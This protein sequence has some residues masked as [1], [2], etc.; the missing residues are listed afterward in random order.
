MIVSLLLRLHRWIALALTLPFA[1]IVISGGLL[2]LEPILGQGEAAPRSPAD[3][4]AL[5]A[6]AERPEAAT[7]RRIALAADGRSVSVATAPGAPAL[8]IDLATGATLPAAGGDFFGFV[9]ALHET[10]LTGGKTVVEAATWAMLAL[11]LT[12]PLLAWP[13]LRNSLGGWH[14]GIGW[15]LFPL[16]LLPV[17]T[18]ALRTL[19]V[20]A[21]PMAAPAPQA[22][23]ASLG[24]ALATAQAAGVDL[25]RLDQARRMGGGAVLLRTGQGAGTELWQVTATGAQR[26]GAGRNWLRDLHDGLWAP[27]WSGW[28]ALAS[29]LA[30]TGL[31]GTG[32][33]AWARRWRAARRRQED[34]GAEFLVAHASQTGRAARTAEATAAALRAGGARV[35][36]A[37]LAALQPGDLARYRATL[38]VVSST[39]EG[40]IADPGQGFLAAL[41]GAELD[42]ARYALLAL[43]DR[44]YPHFCAGGEALRAALG[45]AGATECAPFACADGDPAAAWRD[46][47]A[48]L[49]APLGLRLG[50]AAAPEADPVVSLR[51]AA[52]TRLDDPAAGETREVHAVVLESAEKLEW[53]PGDLVLL[54]PA[55]GAPERCYSIGSA[56]GQDGRRLLLTVAL[57]RQV[58]ADGQ[59]RLG[60]MSGPLCRGLEPG[61][62]LTARL[63][64][65]PA[66]NPPEDPV[67]P[68]IMVAT[69]CGIAPFIGFLG[70]RA[71]AGSR[72]ASWLLFGNRH[73]DGDFLYGPRL[74][75]WLREGVL[76]RLDTAFSRDGA[77]PVHVTDRLV[78][79]AAG[80]WEWMTGR[81]AVLYACGGLSTLGQSLEGALHQVA[82]RAGGLSLAQAEAEVA[83]WQAEGR[84]RRDLID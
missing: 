47:L 11:L 10:L 55:P 54:A 52:R 75:G 4:A 65:H 74:Q 80:I 53:C 32:A 13:R 56:P 35:A 24:T 2:A 18:E 38:L 63:R 15:I 57:R 20:G 76:A 39:G 33:L 12:G 34:A 7:A 16:V 84:L 81:E 51:L 37:S 26:I 23:P 64:R 25:G 71:L 22:R 46:W 9:R 3:A 48:T 5:L 58:D 50:D 8:R 79:Q 28:V 29:A 27:P 41:A 66:F 70:E 72:D 44:R 36:L 77:A 40:R 42:G 68:V 59:E 82:M 61:A 62:M 60:T 43:G 14:L 6:A 69:G 45:R 83:R 31:L 78:E 67:R 19:G 1:V 17:G 21:V 73:Q 49:Q 30:L